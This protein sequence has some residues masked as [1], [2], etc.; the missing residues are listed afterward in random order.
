MSRKGTKSLPVDS[1][2]PCRPYVDYAAV[3]GG[4]GSGGQDRTYA[5]DLR[6][7]PDLLLLSPLIRELSLQTLCRIELP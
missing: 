6:A 2:N 1:L 7:S 4:C 5:Y 3:L